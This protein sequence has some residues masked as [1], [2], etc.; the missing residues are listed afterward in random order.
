MEFSTRGRF[1]GRAAD[2]KPRHV[3][4]QNESGE[5]NLIHTPNDGSH[6]CPSPLQYYADAC[7]YPEEH[8]CLAHVT[9]VQACTLPK[10]QRSLIGSTR[11]LKHQTSSTKT[12]LHPQ[13]QQTNEN[14][15][16]ETITDTDGKFWLTHG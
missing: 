15:I 5:E 3:T 14:A 8:Q 10:D 7:N 9:G 13:P 4:M 2:C 16:T 12:Q 6:H 1:P 11:K